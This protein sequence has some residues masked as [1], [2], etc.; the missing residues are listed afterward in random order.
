MD[1]AGAVPNPIISLR[2]VPAKLALVNESQ[3]SAAEKKWPIE[4]REK[5]DNVLVP[6]YAQV[7]RCALVIR[8]RY[9]MMPGCPCTCVDA[10]RIC[11]A[12][13]KILT[14]Y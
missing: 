9:M 10:T 8:Y 1:S 3:T 5:P 4:D 14:Q 7:Q 11:I 6:M 13:H 2:F 12:D